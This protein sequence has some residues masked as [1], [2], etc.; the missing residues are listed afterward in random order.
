MGFDINKIFI[1][2]RLVKDPELK[3]INTADGNSYD[4]L[5]FTIANSGSKDGENTNFFDCQLWGKSTSYFSNK[6]TKGSPLIVEGSLKQKR[7]T[8]S[9][10][11]SKQSRILI[12]VEKIV[13]INPKYNDFST[14]NNSSS[15]NNKKDIAD[16]IEIADQE[17]VQDTNF[18]QD[19]IGDPNFDEDENNF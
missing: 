1:S 12:N 14:T 6:L 8:N 4:L 9:Q 2:G 3:K 16:E 5:T 15:F 13:L 17:D 10:D 11:N 7:W 19:Q 18:Y